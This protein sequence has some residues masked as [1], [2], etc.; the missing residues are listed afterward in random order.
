MH[1]SR[2]VTTFFLAV[3]FF[4][5]AFLS[6]QAPPT[7]P[8]PGQEDADELKKTAPRVFIDGD[9]VDLAYIKTEIVFVN[10]VR[11]PKEA[12]VHILISVLSTGSGG[13]EYTMTF[14][15]QNEFLGMDDVQKFVSNRTQTSDEIREG[16][17]Q[18][19][20]MG[21][22]RYVAKTPIGELVGINFKEAV[23]PTSVVDKWKF[24][25]FSLSA[26]AYLNGQKSTKSNY[27]YGSF[28]ANRTTPEWKIRTSVNISKSYDSFSYEDTTI[29]SS[30]TSKGFSGMVVKSLGEH[31]SIGGYVAAAQSTY[32][33]YDF[34]FTAAPAIEYDIFPYSISTRRQL[35]ALYRLNIISSD[36][37]EETIY[38]KT[39]ETLFSES[40]ALT[41][42]MKEKWGSTSIE[43][44][45]SHYFHDASKN[46]ISVYGSVSLRIIKGLNFNLYG[47]YSMIH[48]QLSLPKGTATLEEV[49]LRRTLLETNY[50]YYISVGLSY[51]FG[52]IYS[53]VVNP[54]FGGGG[55]IY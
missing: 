39:S 38:N 23:K 3:M 31:W 48:D 28:S 18:V 25:V 11:D 15:G 13:I 49:L 40:L 7:A 33:N 2:S 22:M 17:V 34:K 4:Y 8:P 6:A 27:I 50:S 10:Y 44:E 55:S 29:S 45:G 20:K 24:W 1:I 36:Y 14:S 30:T 26:Q 37:A 32:S 42:S 51:T 54:R 47:S 53:N 43:L 19:L 35:T 52:S 16:I 12:Q 5:P 46:H 9:Y 41:L 21:L